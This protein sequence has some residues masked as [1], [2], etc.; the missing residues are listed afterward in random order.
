MNEASETPGLSIMRRLMLLLLTAAMIGTAADLMLLDHHEDFWQMVPLAVIALGVVSVVLSTLKGGAG[1]VMLMRVTMALFIGSGF[2][3]MGLHYLGNNEFQLEMDPSLHG[4]SLF[5]KSITAKAP[6]ALA[7]AAMIQ[8]GLLGLLY[9][10]KHP[11]LGYS[12][13]ETGSDR[14]RQSGG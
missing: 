2:V 7:P 5:V 1:P 3:G 10:Y 9:T 8:M 12:L 4:W 14:K 13:Q 11:A 6:P